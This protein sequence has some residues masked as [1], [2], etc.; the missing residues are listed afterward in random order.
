MCYLLVENIDVR[1]FTFPLEGWRISPK[2]CKHELHMAEPFKALRMSTI[3]LEAGQTQHFVRTCEIITHMH[4]F[5]PLCLKASYCSQEPSNVLLHGLKFLYNSNTPSNFNQ[6]LC[7]YNQSKYYQVN[8][9]CGYEARTFFKKS[10][11]IL[12][13]QILATPQPEDY[14]DIFSCCYYYSFFSKYIL[15]NNLNPNQEKHTHTFRTQGD[16][17]SLY[18]NSHP[19]CCGKLF[20][21]MKALVHSHSVQNAHIIQIYCM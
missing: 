13:F 2:I 18:P 20:T 14:R 8:F 9:V 15:K 6:A 17:A 7:Q 3:F 19:C 5:I 12:Y 1:H 11:F 21:E 16:Q 4:M 10:L